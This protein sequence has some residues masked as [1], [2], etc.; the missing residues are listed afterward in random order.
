MGTEGVGEDGDE[1]KR[2]KERN[3]VPGKHRDAVSVAESATI[4]FEKEQWEAD[5]DWKHK[6]TYLLPVLATERFPYCFFAVTS[7]AI[8]EHARPST[9]DKAAAA[10]FCLLPNI[11]SKVSIVSLR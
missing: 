3:D 1:Y 7:Q 9:G 5:R 6:G 10:R 8:K 11:D 4:T 2:G